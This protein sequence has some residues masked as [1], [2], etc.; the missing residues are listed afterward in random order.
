MF[1]TG[2]SFQHSAAFNHCRLA[3]GCNRSNGTSAM[4]KCLAHVSK[5]IWRERLATHSVISIIRHALQLKAAVDTVKRVHA[6]VLET[7]EYAVLSPSFS[8]SCFKPP[9]H[10]AGLDKTPDTE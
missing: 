7:G 1:L 2:N 10:E 8:T 5:I 6:T 4:V 9:T 3:A